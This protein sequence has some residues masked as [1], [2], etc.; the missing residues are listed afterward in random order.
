MADTNA[1]GIKIDQAY[2]RADLRDC[3]E[4]A[5]AFCSDRGMKKLFPVIWLFSWLIA[6]YSFGDS[7]TWNLNASSGDWNDAANWTPETVPNSETD[8]AAFSQSNVTNI[9]TPSIQLDSVIFGAD[10]SPYTFTVYNATDVAYLIFW[11]AGVINNSPNEQTFIDLTSPFSSSIQFRNSSTAGD[12]VTYYSSAGGNSIFFFN[13]SNAGSANFIV[14]TSLDFY[15]GGTEQP[16]AANATIDN[17]PGYT[18]FSFGGSAGNAVITNEH[19]GWTD[20]D[21]DG[22][23]GNATIT[24]EG[25][26]GTDGWQSHTYIGGLGETATI[27]NNPAAVR[28]GLGGYTSYGA[29]DPSDSPTI[30]SNGSSFPGGATAG[31]TLIYGN[32][33]NATLIAHGSTNGGAG[34]AILFEDYG[35][36]GGGTSR[37]ELDGNGFLDISV[38]RP[39]GLKIGSV[40]GDGEIFLGANNLGIGT[41]NLSTEFSGLIQDGGRH[42]RPGGAITK[43]GSGTLTLTGANTYTGGTTVGGGELRVSN[44]LGSGTGTGTLQVAAG[45]LGGSGTIS[46][47][48]TIGTGSG[49]GAKLQP[50]FGANTPNTLTLQNSLTFKSDGDYTYKLDTQKGKA[51]EVI[52]N[53]VT[54]ENS[55][56]FI[57]SEIGNKRLTV[58]TVF[59]VISNTS[60][61]PISGTFDSLPD[62]SVITAGPNTLQVNYEGGDGNDLTLTVV[63]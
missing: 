63:Q 4:I 57:L 40:E 58:G 36:I 51:D 12:R 18:T 2:D 8:V 5:P 24:N 43:I 3:L 7:A 38:R 62:G 22:E 35:A 29:T 42:N 39:P 17:N 56:H 37:V 13:S 54:I 32:T 41:N 1:A 53:T 21:L 59:T 30:I 9:S 23:A 45:T 6:H 27:I 19:G 34:G 61:S 55:A 26:L 15:G 46:G 50:G 28:G 11:G 14:N 52:A 31:T 47:A 48:V 33:G 20:F 16:S 10:A 44:T 25:T 60:A 49:A